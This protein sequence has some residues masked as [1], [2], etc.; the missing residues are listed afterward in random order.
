MLKIKAHTQ[1]KRDYKLARKRGMPL[2]A[3]TTVIS[4]LAEGKPLPSRY[5]DHALTNYSR[6]RNARECHILPDWILVYHADNEEL[7][8][9]LLRTGTHS[10][11]F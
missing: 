1:F 10:D 8:L 2:D 7:I 6:Y 11:L 9:S 3:L 4:M 5:R